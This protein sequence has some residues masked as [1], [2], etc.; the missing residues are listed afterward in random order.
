MARETRIGVALMMLL[1][2]VFGF[3]VYQRWNSDR[4]TDLAL[5]GELRKQLEDSK[6]QVDDQ[7]EEDDVFGTEPTL[8]EPMP[9]ADTS[10]PFGAAPLAANVAQPN[11]AQ[12]NAM[13]EESL[14]NPFE[15]SSTSDFAAAE[16]AKPPVDDLFG[17]TPG[18]AEVTNAAAPETAQPE[19][20]PAMAASDSPFG[21]SPTPAPAADENPFGAAPEAAPS[22]APSVAGDAMTPPAEAM[23][24]TP[25][26]TPPA[27]DV[28]PFAPTDPSVAAADLPREIPATAAPAAATPLPPAGN[29]EAAM[30]KE[31]SP[32]PE[33]ATAEAEP[34]G[35][36][37][38]EAASAE[39]SGDGLPASPFT[40]DTKPA[41]AANMAAAPQAETSADAAAPATPATPPEDDPFGAMAASPFS[42]DPPPGAEPPAESPGEAF[43]M[44]AQPMGDKVDV[45]KVEE[46][47]F[48]AAPSMPG[49]GVA[50]SPPAP[51]EEEIS[52]FGAAPDAGAATASAKP[53][54]QPTEEMSPFGAAPDTA[55]PGGNESLTNSGM[56]P[57]QPAPEVA[58]NP[59]YVVK[60]NDTYWTISQAVY[61]SPVYAQALAQFN[62][63]T[64]PD[65]NRLTPGMKV[66]TPALEVLK[67]R[68]GTLIATGSRGMASAQPRMGFFL[69]E[70]GDP[71]FRVSSS[72]TLQDIAQA[73][74]GRPSRWVQIFEMNREVIGDPDKLEPGTILRLPVDA[75]RVRLVSNGGT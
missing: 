48:G 73:H 65:P 11:A 28:M 2:G 45:D 59:E 46:S 42:A 74:L 10:D 21:E 36:A 1:T 31:S 51:A 22:A 63:A 27:E 44:D 6:E 38:M 52:P 33:L 72:D 9:V 3:M 71:A 61:G 16:K 17:N 56:P 58:S 40:E 68:Y 53:P 54:A 26:P 43:A 13:F 24:A 67:E 41:E 7:A 5:A 37:E 29:S 35:A 70:T 30:P 20:A 62:A 4:P 18:K 50:S 64:I 34:F 60:P 19:P 25:E 39:P 57:S 14:G 66:P 12:P 8:A 55:T 49:E 69:T 32:E 23:A 75:S 47:P 15:E